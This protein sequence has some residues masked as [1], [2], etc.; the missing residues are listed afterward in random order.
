M[1]RIH[2][3]L[4]IEDENQARQLAD[5]LREIFDAARCVGHFSVMPRAEEVEAQLKKKDATIA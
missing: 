1:T 3:E 4:E 2:L 5:T